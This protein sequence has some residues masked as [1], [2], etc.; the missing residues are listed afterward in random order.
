MTL[1]ADQLKSDVI[2]FTNDLSS[3]PTL[4]AIEGVVRNDFTQT[5]TKSCEFKLDIDGIESV[6]EETRLRLRSGKVIDVNGQYVCKLPEDMS[7]VRK[8]YIWIDNDD[9]TIVL[10]VKQKKSG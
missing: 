8:T 6:L 7:W 10:C 4:H 9:D 1:V 2:V 5:S 3:T